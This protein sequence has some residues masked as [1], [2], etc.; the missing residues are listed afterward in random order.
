MFI[1]KAVVYLKSGKGGN[2][3]LSFR[4]EKFVPLGGPDGGN[5]G[6]G[7]SVI[8]QADKNVT[9][10][11]DFKYKP[12]FKAKRGRHG[13]GK[14]QHGK[15]GEDLIIQVPLGTVVRE[16]ED[17]P[18]IH[19][20]VKDKEKV[21][22][23]SGGKGGKGNA[24]FVSPVRRAPKIVEEGQEGEEKEVF[25]ELKVIA[26][27]GLVG[28]PNAGK[29]T[30]ISHISN[31]N[32]KVASYPFTTL[33]P[34][35]GVIKVSDYNTFV[36]ADIPGLI[37]GAHNNVGLGHEFLRH[38]ERTT[39][40]LFVLDMG[41]TEGRG[42]YNDY[43]SLL[44]ELKLYKETLTQKMVIVAANKMDI[45]E[46]CE[47]LEN[48]YKQA[49]IP[50]EDIIPVSAVTGWGLEKLISRLAKAIE[51]RKDKSVIGD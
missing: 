43:I 30:L 49:S 12:Y 2:G 23:I 29:S 15:K 19:D 35:L 32:P 28:Y 40:L 11:L 24:C 14:K 33:A 45:S 38:I 48:F 25:L 13:K 1:D 41:N 44:K 36:M 22:I 47:Y 37:K 50:K 31:A 21:I 3:C 42:P 10:L 16:K 39:I 5:G 20:F 46:S 8:F 4:R 17:A 18:L 6:D 9:T 34:H 51:Q 27:V 7:G 26:D